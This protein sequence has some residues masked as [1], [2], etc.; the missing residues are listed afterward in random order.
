MRSGSAVQLFVVGLLVVA[1]VGGVTFGVVQVLDL[2]DEGV[3][4]VAGGDDPTLPEPPDPSA[5]RADQVEVTGFATGVTVEGATLEEIPTPLVVQGGGATLTDVEVDGELAEVVWD[6]G[7]PF[8]LR[9]AGALIPREL[10]VFAAPTA[11]T[12]GF[13]DEVVNEIRPGSYGLETPVAI[14]FAG[15]GVAQDAVAFAATVES[16]IRFRGGSTTS[17]LPRELSFESAGRVVLQG[18]LEV[19]RPDGTSATAAGVELPE[20]SYRLTVTPRPD[21]SGYDIE[22]LLQGSVLV[23]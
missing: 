13:I 3:A 20:G 5:L 17:I 9:G 1:A 14:G 15:V 2:D 8:S 7:R 21:G 19:R 11:I 18:E 12:L 22:A 4:A 16:T 6:G 10:A 23:T